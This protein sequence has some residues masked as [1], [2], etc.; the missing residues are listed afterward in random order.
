MAAGV[1]GKHDENVD[2]LR[3]EDKSEINKFNE[4]VC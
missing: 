4:D 2:D 3:I 1:A